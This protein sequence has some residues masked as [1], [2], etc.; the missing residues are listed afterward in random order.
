[1]D[2]LNTTAATI[3]RARSKAAHARATLS[4]AETA[5]ALRRRQRKASYA[6]RI[7]R[8]AEWTAD[9]LADFLPA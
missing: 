4:E 9:A 6:A 1:M 5:K 2:V 3:R 7:E 8:E